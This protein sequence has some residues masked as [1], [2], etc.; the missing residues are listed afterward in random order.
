ES[1]RGHH[2]L[3]FTTEPVV[4]HQFAVVLSHSTMINSDADA[5]SVQRLSHELNGFSRL[6]VHN[7]G[8]PLALCAHIQDIVQFIVTFDIP[9]SKVSP[10]EARPVNFRLTE[11]ELKNNI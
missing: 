8:F 5:L 6:A 3:C 11:P 9:V 7:T 4:Q 10:F 2:Y 1:I